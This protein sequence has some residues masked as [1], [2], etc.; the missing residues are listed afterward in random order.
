MR[1]KEERKNNN[2]MEK[3]NN[4][5]G[6][7]PKGTNGLSLKAHQVKENRRRR[8]SIKG[9]GLGINYTQKLK[10]HGLQDTTE[11]QMEHVSSPWKA[12]KKIF[13]LLEIS[14]G[15]FCHFEGQM[16]LDVRNSALE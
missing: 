7:N 2:K 13:N 10:R 15:Q 16:G 11:L 8:N 12:K 4:K 1:E 3:N 6:Q 9:R 14:L 5:M